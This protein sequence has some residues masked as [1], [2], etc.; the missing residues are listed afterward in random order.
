MW[1]NFMDMVGRLV[2]GQEKDI[3]L[4]R[5]NNPL[6]YYNNMKRCSVS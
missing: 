4:F 1:K 5:G 3:Y 2:N 6:A